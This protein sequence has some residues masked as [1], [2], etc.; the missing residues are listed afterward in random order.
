MP[1]EELR[2]LPDPGGSRPSKVFVPCVTVTGRSVLSRSVKHGMPSAVVSSCTPPESVTTAAAPA[3][4][5]RK[6]V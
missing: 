5:E 2:D 6:G 3:S 1:R 4:S